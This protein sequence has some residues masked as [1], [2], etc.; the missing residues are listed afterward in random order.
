MRR[1]QGGK[2]SNHGGRMS[3]GRKIAFAFLGLTVGAAAGG[4][5]GVADGLSWTELMNTSSFEGYSGYVV[6]FWMLG[7]I[8]LGGAAGLIF[9]A[10][11]G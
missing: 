10:V 4:G 1:K 7:G 11:K 9:G 5:L 2:S 6:A 3:A 8:I